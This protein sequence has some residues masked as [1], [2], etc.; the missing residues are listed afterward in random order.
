ME[1][2][3]LLKKLTAEDQKIQQKGRDILNLIDGMVNSVRRIASNLR[4]GI[5]DDLGLIAALEWHSQEV[6]IQ[7]GIKI[8]F[9][10]NTKELNLPTPISTSLFRIYQEALANVVRNSTAHIVVS[11]LQINDTNLILEVKDDGQGMDPVIKNDKKTLGLIDIIERTF[12]LGGQF[13][14]NSEPGKGTEIK[15]TIPL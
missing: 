10:V 14:L 11:H 15:I 5:L 2:Y 13:E 6:E 1:I 7:S 8:D 3:W 9:M 12:L 4:P